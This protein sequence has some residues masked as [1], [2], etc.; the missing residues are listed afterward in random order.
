VRLDWYR[1][2]YVF[3]TDGKETWRTTDGGVSQ[4]PNFIVFSEEIGNFGTGP[5]AWGVGP[6]EK[7]NLPDYFYVDY[8]R[9]YV[10]MPP[11]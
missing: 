7:A 3:F 5:D 9:V 6:I 10:Y 11:R 2:Q 1:D 8:V 4:A